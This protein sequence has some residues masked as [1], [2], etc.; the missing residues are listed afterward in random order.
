LKAGLEVSPAWPGLGDGA[1]APFGTTGSGIL[2]TITS[3]AFGVGDS[4]AFGAFET[5]AGAGASVLLHPAA[6]STTA[7]QA[8]TPDIKVFIGRFLVSA[9][10]NRDPF[11]CCALRKVPSVRW[12]TKCAEGYR[13]RFTN[14]GRYV[15][16]RTEARSRLHYSVM[17]TW[18][19]SRFA[20]QKFNQ[21]SRNT[22]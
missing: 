8:A 3:V 12:R 16:K 20:G 4:A 22:P 2:G 14:S 1:S 19:R 18:H 15:G 9:F 6:S 7:V 10:V 21:S 13:C 11:A 5:G 17:A